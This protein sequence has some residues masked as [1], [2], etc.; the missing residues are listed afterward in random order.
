MGAPIAVHISRGGFRVIGFDLNPLCLA[1]ASGDIISAS[2]CADLARQSDL[3]VVV[4]GRDAEVEAALF[5]ENGVLDSAPEGAI[6]VVASTVAPRTMSQIHVRLAGQ[7][8]HLV[9]A[10][11][12]RGEDAARA[13]KLFAFV[14]G[15]HDVV[16]AARPVLSTFA[17]TIHHLGEVGAGQVGKLVNSLIFWACVSANYEGM[18]LGHEFGIDVRTL[19]A[20]LIESSGQNWALSTDAGAKPAPT[21]EKDMMI[22]LQAADDLRISLPLSGVV[23]EV[24]KGIKIERSLANAPATTSALTRRLGEN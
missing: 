2:S 19:H 22:I 7:P 9:D 16:A 5:G 21:A 17:D 10:P 8:V 23:K 18:K 24:I 6:I 13:G 1:S 11:L 14:G 3:I 4:V 15:E 20:A 12:A